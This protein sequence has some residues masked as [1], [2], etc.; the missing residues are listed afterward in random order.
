MLTLATFQNSSTSQS[1]IL[2]ILSLLTPILVFVLS[3]RSIKESTARAVSIQNNIFRY[4]NYCGPG[5]DELVWDHTFAV[6]HVDE[7]CQLHDKSY[8]V[9][10]EQLTAKIGYK[11]PKIINQIMP[12]RFLIPKMFFSM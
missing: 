5:P 9:C 2:V 12:I 11:M 7:I 3:T 1:P 10:N 6:D 8:R 4:G